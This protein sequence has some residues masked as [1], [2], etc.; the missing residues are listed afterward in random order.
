MNLSN[1]L[2]LNAGG[3]GSG[4]HSEGLSTSD[5][6]DKVGPKENKQWEEAKKRLV[7]LVKDSS[8]LSALTA[9]KV[10]EKPPG[11]SSKY[12]MGV[13]ASYIGAGPN[14][15][16][17][18]ITKDTNFLAM[19]HEIGHAVEDSKLGMLGFKDR[20]IPSEHKVEVAGAFKEYESAKKSDDLFSDYAGKSIHEWFAEAFKYVADSYKGDYE[21][22]YIKN[23]APKTF[24]LIMKV[25]GNRT[26]VKAGGP[27]SGRH[28]YGRKEKD[29][30][31]Q[32]KA[33]ASYNPSNRA[34][35]VQAENNEK[36]LAKVVK[37]ASH[38]GDNAPFD[39][40]VAKSR[41][42]FEV[43]TIVAGKNDKITMHKSSRLR[44]LKAWKQ[45]KLN[46]VYTVIFDDREGKKKIYLG[47]GVSSFRLKLR[48]GE[49][50]PALTV[51]NSL[52]DIKK[53]I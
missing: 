12:G 52:K 13:K 5:L 24:N 36:A 41:I 43:K 50:N 20:Q 30:G 38:V 8:A 46:N 28:P 2:Q 6:L 16:T 48:S 17:L 33:L 49:M 21:K 53:L 18:Y 3:P 14:K 19:L 34:K 29:K 37:G 27:G 47:N 10:V 22:S 26:D 32:A 7:A 44:K 51:L 45:M 39:V 9:V 35:Q 31:R 1:L 25:T 11:D 40:I 4:R 23:E 15:G 42:A